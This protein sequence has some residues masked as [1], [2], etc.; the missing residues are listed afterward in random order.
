VVEQ[1]LGLLPQ[2]SLDLDG[3]GTPKISDADLAEDTGVELPECEDFTLNFEIETT[4][5]LEDGIKAHK[6]REHEKAWECFKYHAENES[7]YAKHW[8]GYYLWEGKHVQKN[9]VE[10]A[11][12][13]KEAADKGI[14]DAQ[15]RYAFTLQ[16][17]LGKKKERDEFIKYLTL[18]ADGGNSTAQFNLGDVYINGK[19]NVP[20]D[21]KKGI[22]YLKLSALQSQ[23]N[24]VKLLAKM[25]IDFT[26]EPSN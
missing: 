10:A 18:A 19:L 8:M 22:H 1:E 2:K 5:T 21:E 14:H 15:L 13:F 3:T 12:L 9:Q 16:K 25:K 4:I 6:N 11:K 26:E 7:A 17:D 24:A 23:P 20:K